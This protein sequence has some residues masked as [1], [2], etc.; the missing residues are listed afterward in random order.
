MR[1]PA[2]ASLNWFLPVF[3]CTHLEPQQRSPSEETMSSSSPERYKQVP[4]TTN[5][6]VAPFSSWC[7]M[8]SLTDWLELCL[9]D[10]LL[11]VEVAAD[12]LH[13]H[14]SPSKRPCKGLFKMLSNC[15][16]IYI[17]FFTPVA[18]GWP[19]VLS[20]PGHL[21]A[22]WVF[23]AN[24]GQRSEESCW[25]EFCSPCTHGRLESVV[26]RKLW[27]NLTNMQQNHLLIFS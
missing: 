6:P 15:P 3:P 19:H 24:A 18:K 7:R 4:K 10:S 12:Q 11:S 1:I 17:F 9:R 23:W 27:A 22:S 20:A 26:F 16:E 13:L 21:R 5:G 25:E 14:K 2:G 8:V